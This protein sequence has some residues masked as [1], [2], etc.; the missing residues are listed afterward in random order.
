MSG[1]QPTRIITTGD[2]GLNGPEKGL[3]GPTS[4]LNGGALPLNGALAC[5][6]PAYGLDQCLTTTS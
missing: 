3:N 4:G 6:G 2:N 1:T 5:N